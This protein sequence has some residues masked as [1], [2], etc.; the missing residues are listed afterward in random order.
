MI[1]IVPISHVAKESTENVKR[2][3]REL[4]PDFVAVELC[5]ERTARG[6]R[7]KVRAGISRRSVIARILVYFQEKYARKVGTKA[8][9]EMK[10]AMREAKKIGAEVLLIDRPVSVTLERL[11]ESISVWDVLRI[12]WQGATGEELPFDLNSV[13]GQGVVDELV[14][15][16]KS[17]FPKIYKVLITERDAH[18]AAQLKGRDNAVAVIGAGHVKG[19]MRLLHENV[20]LFGAGNP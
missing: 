2:A 7:E 8:G 3:I 19:V 18:M 13:P 12:L 1:T 5:P 17:E 15:E 6:S 10:V 11:S 20:Q 4:K 16:L 14:L 9:N